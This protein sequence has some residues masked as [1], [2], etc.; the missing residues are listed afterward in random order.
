[1]TVPRPVD[2]TLV[3]RNFSRQA[4]SYDGYAQVQQRAAERLLHMLLAERT[5]TGRALE[6]GT[7][8]GYLG[9]ALHA[10]LPALQLAVSDLAHGMTRQA[11]SRIPLALAFD[12]DAQFLPLRDASVELV[13][14]SSVY[15]WVNE[16]SLAF[17]EAFRVL[18]E[19]GCFAFTLFGEQTL[20]ELRDAHRQAAA[21]FGRLSHV[22]EFPAPAEIQKEL[23]AAGFTVLRQQ[24]DLEVQFHPEVRELLRALKAIG[25]GNA[26]VDRPTGLASRQLLER[27]M[28]L[29]RQCYG[30]RRGIPATWQIISVVAQKPMAGNF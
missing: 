14:S 27:M 17:R 28:L 11:A 10:S 4:N 18:K 20:C 30:R 6:I 2:S 3:R 1:M 8:T 22:Q 24:A 21:E 7:G 9:A 13:L 26:A 23:V 16:L 12:A 25:A 29:Y 19:G 15:Q 5:V